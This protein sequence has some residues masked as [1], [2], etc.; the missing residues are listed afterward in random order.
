[1]SRGLG[2]DAFRSDGLV[3]ALAVDTYDNPDRQDGRE[4]LRHIGAESARFAATARDRL[5]FGEVLDGPEGLTRSQLSAWLDEFLDRR[6]ERKILYWTGHGV[7]AEGGFHLACRDSWADGPFAPDRSFA[8][9]ELVDRI[10]SA[11]RPAHTLLVLD[12]CS[13]H[14]HLNVAL[15]RAVSKERAAVARAYETS[16]AGFA[17]IGTSG[18]GA[19]IREGLWVGWLSSVLG[20]PDTEVSDR[21]LPMHRSHLY[22][23]VPYLVE[24]IDQEAAREGLETRDER[25]GF[26]MVRHLPNNFL[27]NPYFQDEGDAALRGQWA[28]PAVLADDAPLPWARE[29][30]FQ[31]QEGGVLEREFTGRHAALSRLVRW[32]DTAAH[33]T[34]VVTG[35]G[36]S[37]KTALLA[38]VALLS[39]ARR[40]T[41]L[42]PQP[43]PQI[44]PRPGTVHALVTCRDRSLSAVVEAV[45]DALSTFGAMP[46]K[47][48]TALDAGRCADAVAALAREAGALNLLFDGLDEAM[49]GQAHEI[50]RQFLNRLADT[51]GVKVIVATR[52]RPRRQ[53]A[54]PVGAE[55]LLDVL[56][57]TTAP[58]ALDQDDDAERDITALAESLLAA[59]GSPYADASRALL[60][61]EAAQ[62]I[63]AESDGLFLV[64]RLVA[65][66]L[67]R[68]PHPP[69]AAELEAELRQAGTGLEEW[70]RREIGHLEREG[71]VPAAGILAPL[72]LAHGG[73]LR[74][75]SLLVTMADALHGRAGAFT[76]AQ[77]RELL[78]LAEGGLVAVDSGTY[79]LA[80]AGY[81][82]H[83]LDRLGLTPQSGHREIHA[84][85]HARGA[86]DW[87]KADAYTRSYLAAHA[88]QADEERLR[89]LLDDPEFLVHTDPDVVLPLAVAQV[90]PSEGAALYVRVADEFRR[91]RDPGARRALLRG[92]AFVSHREGMYRRLTSEGFAGLG[93]S[94]LWTDA[95]PEPVDL[96]WPAAR[97]GARA[98]HWSAVTTPAALATPAGGGWAAGGA[99]PAAYAMPAGVAPA[100]REATAARGATPAGEAPATRE[101]TAA[102]DATRPGVAPATREATAAGGATPVGVAPAGEAAA[103]GEAAAAGGATAAGEGTS[104]GEEPDTVLSLGVLGAVAV[105]D[106]RTGRQRLTRRAPDRHRSLRQVAGATAG[107]RRVTAAADGSA[108]L[109]WDDASGLP[110]KVFDWGGAPKALAVAACGGHFL[111]MAADGQRVWTWQWPADESASE[112]GLA[113]IL[114]VAADR[115]ALFSLGARHFLLSAGVETLVHQV[116]PAGAGRQLLGSAVPLPHTGRGPVRALAA[117]PEP[118]PRAGGPGAPAAWLARADGHT[119]D[120][121]R[122]SLTTGGDGR[123][124]PG[125]AVAHALSLESPDARGMALGHLGTRPLLVLHQG[126]RVAVHGLDEEGRPLCAFPVH[127][128]RDPEALACDPGGSGRVAVADGPHVRILDVAAATAARPGGPQR[129][130]TERLM[131]E[132]AAGPPGRPGLLCRVTGRVVVAGYAGAPGPGGGDPVPL[133][134]AEP[135]TA[136]RAVWHDGAWLVAAAA[137]RTVRVWSLTADLAAATPYEDITLPGDPGEEIRGLGL[138]V[139]ADGAPSVF[140]P[141]RR[142][143][144]RRRLRDGRWPVRGEVDVVAHALDVRILSDGR[145]WVGVDTGRGFRLW[146]AGAE[147]RAV[148]AVLEDSWRRT[149]TMVLGEHRVLG[150]SVPLVAWGEDDMV[151]LARYKG[152]RWIAHRFPYPGG[153]AS[154]LLFTGPP[155]R[156][157]LVACGGELTLAV[158]DATTRREL[159]AATVPWRGLDVEAVGA[160]YEEGRGITLTLQGRRRCDQIL[161]GTRALDPPPA[162][163]P[164]PGGDAGAAP[165]AGGWRPG[166]G[167]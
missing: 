16:A 69:S 153:R 159:K 146:P 130:Y 65:G 122:L 37:G 63:A 125:W 95:A 6:A 113:G 4:H 7:D 9:T 128:H 44:C 46:P 124:A 74:D 58:L 139:E 106:P 89:D 11:P 17:V 132:H 150:T 91:R 103:T 5:G 126:D 107:P 49:P 22:L 43:P 48:E 117:L 155:E 94:E 34:Q 76:R 101:A 86:P 83:I 31:L 67:A 143:V 75:L 29:S 2:R 135:V 140:V 20:K 98:L 82:A 160:V 35:P 19:T 97:G 93:W 53:L 164:G 156:P 38:M 161:L 57:Q 131:V 23:S 129:S 27:H 62:A 88:A 60:R 167:W 50:A 73:G 100:T 105:H 104:A 152:D 18:V 138:V 52:P 66:Q 92:T 77:A 99:T 134:L 163:R 154:A 26:E 110:A 12:A 61:R 14:G 79:R 32:L 102:G 115:L 147:D 96:R 51:R 162:V 13:S 25:P 118:V 71:A 165:G 133:R 137:G 84:V 55:S 90:G 8:L 108:V 120:V 145:T 15:R 3:G 40:R 30:A 158:F 81:G 151:H 127:G 39:V 109:V 114:P 1:M 112:A 68:R 157:L 142:T 116:H 56:D 141:D 41:R 148:P 21:S 54:D 80:H 10:L 166:P 47:P 64:A 136:V 121:W 45:W 144:Q 28:N 119:T 24:A 149:A 33:G 111:A 87:G 123:P 85:L 59:P 72:A 36:G 78:A 70:V 42:D